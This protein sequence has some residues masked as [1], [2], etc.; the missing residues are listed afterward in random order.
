MA[1]QGAG[2]ASGP[3]LQ[4][5][6]EGTARVLIAD[7]DDATRELIAATLRASGYEVVTASDG[8]EAAELVARGG[9]DVV[10][11]DA[12]MPR[13]S[14]VDACRTIKSVQGDAF[15]PVALV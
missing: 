10:L 5:D 6:E 3:L 2:R 1:A 7:D 9:F 12:V 11:L 13:T 4:D 14:G 8:Q 15:V